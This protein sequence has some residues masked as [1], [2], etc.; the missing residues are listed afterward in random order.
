MSE[1]P[2]SRTRGLIG[3]ILS[4]RGEA[5][6]LEPEDLRERVARRAQELAKELKASLVPAKA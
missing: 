3:E 5:V 4:D 2:R 1:S 6:L